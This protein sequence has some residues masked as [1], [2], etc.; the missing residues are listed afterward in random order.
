MSGK[1]TILQ[2]GHKNGKCPQ[3][4]IKKPIHQHLT[5]PK[6]LYLPLNYKGV[7]FVK[8]NKLQ[9]IKQIPADTPYEEHQHAIPPTYSAAPDVKS[10]NK[11]INTP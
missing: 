1:K 7:D 6:I 3:V 5:T 9:K 11:P 8:I 4:L 10:S 2:G